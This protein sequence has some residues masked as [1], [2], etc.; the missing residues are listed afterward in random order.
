MNTIKP[1][2]TI[3]IPTYN[4]K[5]FLSECLSHVVSQIEE[6]VEILVCDN[7]STDDTEKFMNEYC[8]KYEFIRYI[9]NEKN[10]GPDGNFLKCLRE[11]KGEF[12]H[13]LSDDDIMLDGSIK[14]IKSCIERNL[15]LSFLHLNLCVFKG[16]YSDSKFSQKKYQISKDMTFNNRMEFLEYIGLYG[17]FVSSMVFNS[18]IAKNIH[19]PEQY[20][21]S[22]LLQTHLMTMSLKDNKNIA[23]VAHECI[24]QR[25]ENTGGYNLFKV[26]IKEYKKVLFITGKTSGLK[27]VESRKIYGKIIREIG[28]WILYMK[29]NKSYKNF[30]SRFK[31]EYFLNTCTYLAA[32]KCLFPVLV[33][34]NKTLDHILKVKKFLGGFN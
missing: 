4:R 34:N 1:I 13:L 2:L 5:E 33:I 3:A 12:I 19:N 25:D 10:I 18:E 7:A 26:F 24:A 22:M 31:L 14:S 9:R 17:T 28:S 29:K 16:K 6:D 11:G 8:K 23:V 21:G 20:I 27:Y 32:W 15:N 30:D